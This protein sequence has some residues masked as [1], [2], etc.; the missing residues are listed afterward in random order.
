[1]KLIF[2][3]IDGVLVTHRH[4][5][6]EEGLLMNLKRIVDITGADIVLSSDWRRHPSARLEAKRVLNAVGLNFIACTPCMSAFLAQRPTEIM[7]WKRDHSKRADAERISHWVVIDDRP[8]LEERH[9]NYL[10]G[11]F[12]QTQPMRGLTDAVVDE[13]C[14]IL[15]QEAD[16]RAEDAAIEK[17]TNDVGE[18]EVTEQQTEEEAAPVAGVYAC[19]KCRTPLFRENHIQPH[20]TEGSKKASR[21]WASDESGCTSMFLEPMQ[22]MGDCSAQTGKLVCANAK[23][24]QKLGSFSW[25]GLPCSCGQWQSPAFQ[26]HTARIE[27]LPV[28]KTHSGGS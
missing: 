6:F 4:G 10:R 11:H 23:C 14:R 8:L 13:C 1:M 15:T 28:V 27:L 22:W 2:L 21:R 20:F 7:Q 12:A 16:P 25:H 9:G 19:V 17:A 5:V 3:D 24:G 26:V 18:A